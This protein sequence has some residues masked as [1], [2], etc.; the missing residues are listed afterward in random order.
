MLIIII[1]IIDNGDN[2]EQTEEAANILLSL[3][4]SKEWVKLWLCPVFYAAFVL[5]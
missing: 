2:A 4:Y 1:I 5:N 3:K